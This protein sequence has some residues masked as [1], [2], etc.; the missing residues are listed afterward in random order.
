VRISKNTFEEAGLAVKF[1]AV[2]M[3]GFV[4]DAILL[5]GGLELH[6]SPAIAR[7]ISLALAMQVTFAINRTH[8][9]RCCG[10][11]GLLRQWCG[12]MATNGFGNFC[13]YWIFLTLTSL[14]GSVVSEPFVAL[15]ISAFTA[16][17]INYAGVRLVVFGRV[18][19]ER[20]LSRRRAPAAA[21]KPDQLGTT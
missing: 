8:V 21:A 19:V 12:Y 20:R 4:V 9:F 16:Y 18:R 17:L 10:T 7:L 2:G 11:E 5:K 13:N 14:H 15:P 1:A 6:L 3:I